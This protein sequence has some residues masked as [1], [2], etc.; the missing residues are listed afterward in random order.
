MFARSNEKWTAE[1][2]T[3]REV[4][5]SYNGV[6]QTV[7]VHAHGRE[8]IY[9]SAPSK[10]LGDQRA[11]YNQDFEFKLRIGEPEAVPT[12]EDLILEGAGLSITQPIFGQNNPLPNTQVREKTEH[13]IILTSKSFL[14]FV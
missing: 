4:S 1:D 11:S 2:V 3:Q 7:G 12:V 14:F 5:L 10:F 13:R 9:F 6:T 8:P